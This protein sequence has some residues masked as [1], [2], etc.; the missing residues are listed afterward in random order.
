MNKN[1]NWRRV[2][3]LLFAMVMVVS[4]A[5]VGTIAIFAEEVD[6]VTGEINAD[7]TLND[8]TNLAGVTLAGGTKEA[9]IVI[10][11]NGTVTVS[12]TIRLNS[13][14][15]TN[16]KFVGGTE[17]AM[18]TRAEGFTGQ[19][20]YCEGVSGNFHNVTFENI[21]L[22]GGAVWTGDEDA[23]LGR[24]T[25]NSGIKA[26]GSTLYLLYTNVTLEN[27]VLQN[28]DDSTG[29][30]AN[31][32][33]LRYYST[34][35]FNNSVV[36]NNASPSGYYSG[37]VI[38]VRQG[39]TAKTNNSEVYGNYGAQGGFF[40]VS[41]TGSYGGICEVYDS[42]FHNNFADAGA[43][44]DMQCNSNKGYLLIDGCE[45]YDNGSNRGLIYEHAYSRPVIIKDSTFQNN[46]CAIW[47]CHTAPVLDL[48]GKIVIEGDYNGYFFQ[49]PL[50]ISAPLAEGSYIEMSEATVNKLMTSGYLLTG[51]AGY[52]VTEADLAKLALPEGYEFFVAD[53]NGDG[54]GDTVSVTPDKAG[55]ISA[56]TLVLKDKLDAN[57]EAEGVAYTG[58]TCLPVCSFAH[59]G[60]VFAGWVDADGNAV[61]KQSFTESTT[62]YATWKL[63]APTLKLSRTD[64]TLAVNVTNYVESLTYTYQWYM[65]NVAIEGATASTYTMTD[66][67]SHS[68]KCEVTATLGEYS[69]AASAS[70][71]SSA[72]AAAQI[73][74]V[75]YASL[76]DA[77][78]AANAL[79]SATITLYKNVTL[80]E[81]LTVT[82]NVTVTGAY[83]ITRA[84]NYT[85]T[86][87]VVNAGAT[88]TL[89]GGL[90]IDGGNNWT[91]D[92]TGFMAA[93]YDNTSNNSGLA[94]VTPE[95]GAPCAT[96]PMFDVIGGNLVL[97][98]FTVKNHLSTAGS[99]DGSR[100]V[101][102]LSSAATLVMNNGATVTHCATGDASTVAGLNEGS[103]WTI[104]EGAVIT[105]NYGGRNGAMCRNNNSTI[106]MNGGSINNNYSVN[107]NG[108]IFMM[109]GGGN[110]FQMNGGEICSN[111]ATRGGNG[112]TS[113]IYLHASGKMV[114]TGGAI[115]HNYGSA[116]A[117]IDTNQSSGSSLT[118][119]GGAIVDNVSTGNNPY[120][121]IFWPAA[122]T[123][124]VISGGTFTQDVSKWLA[125]DTGLVYVNGVYTT[126]AHADYL[127]EIQA[128]LEAGESVVLDRDIVITD[129]SF[130][131]VCKLPSNTN[132]KYG[133]DVGNGAIFHITKPGVV[134]DLNGHSIVWDAHDAAYCN[135]RQVSL[136]QVTGSGYAG[137][138]ADFTVIDSVGSGK[139]DIYGMPSAMYVVLATA[140]ATISGGTWTNYP[141]NTCEAWNIFMYPSHGGALYITGGT[142][143]Q[144]VED[145]YLLYAV[146]S[147]KPYNGN[148]VGVDYDQTK[149]VIS[150]G[151]FIGTNPGDIKFQDISSQLSDYNA[152]E[153]GFAPVQNADGTWG[154]TFV[155]LTIDGIPFA[156]WADAVEYLKVTAAN[157]IVL[158]GDVN[159]VASEITFFGNLGGVKSSEVK[160]DLNG[161]N[162]Y[163]KKIT[164]KS[165]MK[166]VLVDSSEDKTGSFTLVSTLLGEAR[167]VFTIEDGVEF[168]ATLQMNN[169]KAQPGT[170]VLGDVEFVGVNGVFSVDQD[171][172]AYLHVGIA[173]PEMS[174]NIG[175]GT[176]NLNRDYT[177][178]NGHKFT[179][180]AQGCLN[181]PEGVTLTI[182]AGA[183][184]TLASNK[185]G[186]G[187]ITGEGAV[188][189]STFEH[190][191]FFVEKT[192][193]KNIVLADEITAEGYVL[194]NAE[195][196]YV[197][198]ENLLNSGVVITA[199]TFDVDVKS[200]CAEGYA[201]EKKDGAWV[202]VPGVV[203]IGD[204]Y[205]AS[206]SAA[207][208]AVKSGETITLIT[209]LALNSAVTFGH[210]YA[211]VVTLDLNGYTITARDAAI[212][213]FRSGTVLTVT[214]GTLNG[215]SSNG[216]L[217]ATY[218]AKLVLGDNLTVLSG[219]RA[220]AIVLDSG[221]LEVTAGATIRVQGGINC[222]ETNG[223]STNTINITGGTFVGNLVINAN[224]TCVITGGAFT[225]NVTLY[226]AEGYCVELVDDT[227]Y[228]VDKHNY[229]GVETAPTVKE[230]GFTT[231][232]CTRCGDSYVEVAEGTRLP[233]D[234]KGTRL[235]LKDGIGIYFMV[236]A[237][238]LRS[239]ESYVAVITYAGTRYE[240]PFDD[241][242]DFGDGVN[243]GIL[244]DGI[245]AKDLGKDVS[246][247]LTVDG[248]EVSVTRTTNVKTYA[249]AIIDCDKYTADAKALAK[250]LLNYGALAE[251]AIL[252]AEN[253]VNDEV[254]ADFEQLDVDMNEDSVTTEDYYGSS[255]NLNNYLGFN[256][257]FFANAVEG[258]THAVIT[259]NGKTV[260]VDVSAFTTE[261]KKGNAL[262]VI[263]LEQLLASD[264]ASELTCTVYNGETELATATDSVYNYCAR[265]LA[266]LEKM[267]GNAY[268]AQ[269]YKSE[270]YKALVLYVEA[271]KS[272]TEAIA[273]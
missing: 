119:S 231:Y 147:S 108:S 65:D 92:K 22:D 34:I 252:G 198:A 12:D 202:V 74:D 117:G 135:K 157:E 196:N 174:I 139:V 76:K 209:D 83:T 144:K 66:V 132:G 123:G 226:C 223:T 171:Y 257:K 191:A 56:V 167:N 211:V 152:C 212:N 237:T 267:D 96:A 97:N 28:H 199:G 134:L 219:G 253:D 182:D 265:A 164:L 93:I 45:F 95:E 6:G 154:V 99:N 126:Y 243:L 261:T 225:V 114:M 79:E 161:Y 175:V 166:F 17:D 194:D 215:N 247:V 240:V 262:V 131:H 156:S 75:K 88:L 230:N 190:L 170:L 127:A 149:L 129:Y 69:T 213:A 173:Y 64:A 179:V 141:C 4:L 268:A 176:L 203:K 270:F 10:T 227:W 217:R 222:L 168:E 42:V 163:A 273:E 197:G 239:D 248:V 60:F 101:F 29:E 207:A 61:A 148:S 58:I 205:Y 68:Y 258:A 39:G 49:T 241:W 51:A 221:K 254:N 272:Y 20:F 105:G 143:E 228:V 77:L 140:K 145:P 8:G 200:L 110:L 46:E 224:S 137:E 104:N 113:A 220:D 206:L 136:F 242:T 159:D 73:G 255:V 38:T 78:A 19:M 81:K 116:Y 9:P 54:V 245:E 232:T 193:I 266:G 86:L 133:L 178:A 153:E 35:T 37:G 195:L 32:V 172:T 103:V 158:Y 82:G 263:E 109:Y 142:F 188:A 177:I 23:T 151:T 122:N 204:V 181:I 15:I 47:D 41:S 165:G 67:N 183:T 128:K 187:V 246:V 120:H 11:I 85:G 98:N 250:A 90:V 71:T 62:L 30:K 16:V 31:A 80:G 269:K 138:T 50:A 208:A 146:L 52:Q 130:V 115:C 111:Y 118:I 72:P 26:T 251:N 216:T 18:L 57:A 238:K 40:G 63:N 185:N 124:A 150:G 186:T 55:S 100:A 44:F 236:D 7:I 59:E 48:S 14:A 184:V 94:F 160:F 201:T 162:F 1:Q 249:Q 218:N 271:A 43:L 53:V 2:L 84:D 112:R 36:R 107:A 214:N 13:T 25:V 244:F 121:D 5:V 24:G 264:A 21:T 27:S 235:L 125:N 102:K 189:V 91:F 87:F 259:Y 169:T 233:L 3:S 256:F 106:I 260:E 33:F 192:G 89:D 210:D 180:G 155:A 70:G 229:V 234:F